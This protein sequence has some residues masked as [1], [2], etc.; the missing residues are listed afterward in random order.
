LGGIA[1]L[2]AIFAGQAFY[3]MR[4]ERRRKDGGEVSGRSRVVIAWPTYRRPAAPQKR[5]SQVDQPPF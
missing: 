5:N 3:A 1:A 2:E 4:H